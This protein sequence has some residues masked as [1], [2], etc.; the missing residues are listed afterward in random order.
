MLL[1]LTFLT[2]YHKQWYHWLDVYD[3]ELFISSISN[4][5]G[6]Y[7]INK[8]PWWSDTISAFHSE[9][10][11]SNLIFQTLWYL[12]YLIFLMIQNTLP[13]IKLLLTFLCI[14]FIIICTALFLFKKFHINIDF[15]VIIE[16][17]F[18]QIIS[19]I[20]VDNQ[21]FYFKFNLDNRLELDNS[22]YITKSDQQ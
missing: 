21:K 4:N 8:I 10:P 14:Y 6:N 22:S 9:I 16:H 20:H 2:K 1:K 3:D 11:V 12:R 19:L 5:R 17:Y 13:S 15:W 18:F 7:K